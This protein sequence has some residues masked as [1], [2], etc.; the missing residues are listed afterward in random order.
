LTEPT[1][2]ANVLKYGTGG[3]NI[4]GS[5]VGTSDNVTTHSRGAGYDG[6][7][8]GHMNPLPTRKQPG[9]EAGRWPANLVLQ[10]LEGCVQTG[11]REDSFNTAVPG[12]HSLQTGSSFSGLKGIGKSQRVNAPTTTPVYDCKDGCP[13]A[14]LDTQGDGASR[15]FKQFG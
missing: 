6:P 12:T 14:A 4:D 15:F 7:A 3:L 11:V 2:V 5:R 13:V 10:H 9:Q 1:V 8:F